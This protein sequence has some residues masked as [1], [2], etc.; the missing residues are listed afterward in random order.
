MDC[1]KF[2]PDHPV[3]VRLVR[4]LYGTVEAD[5]V[6]AGKIVTTS[7]FSKEAKEFTETVRYRMSLMDFNEIVRALQK[8]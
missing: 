2:S 6:T 1:K 4:E 3:G 7:Y 5:K 8:V